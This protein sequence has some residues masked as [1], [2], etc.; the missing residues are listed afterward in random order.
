MNTRETLDQ[1]ARQ[2]GSLFGQQDLPGDVQRNLRALMQA[3]LTK[4][5]L[6]TREEFENQ[7]AVLAR[8]RAKLD[9]L[10]AQLIELA[11]QLDTPDLPH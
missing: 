6:V 2:I 1:L 4:M 10:E 8:T 5:D 9:Q 3:G 11:K 7:A